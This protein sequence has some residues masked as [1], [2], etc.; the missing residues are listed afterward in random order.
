MSITP[1]EPHLTRVIR[2]NQKNLY[3]NHTSIAH[4]LTYVRVIG[5]PP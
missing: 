5:T 1:D 4:F 2:K 3:I